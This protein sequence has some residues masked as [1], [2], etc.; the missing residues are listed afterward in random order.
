[1]MGRVR[2]NRMTVHQASS[3]RRRNKE[4][5][6]HTP[7]MQVVDHALMNQPDDPALELTDLLPA[8]RSLRVAVVTETYPPEVNGVAVTVAR[9]VEGLLQRGH[10]IQL[11][12]PRQDSADSRMNAS[13]LQEMLMR[14][15]PIPRYPQLRLGLPAKAALVAAW[16]K[17][18]PDMVHIATQGPLGWSALKAARKLRLP[19]STDFRTN[20]HA[21][22]RHYGLGWLNRT[23]VAYLRKFHNQAALTMVPTL[24]LRE[25]LAALGFER[26]CVVGRGVDTR[27]FGP[28]WRSPLLRDRW[29]VAVDDPVVLYVG[30]IAPEKNLDLLARAYEAMCQRRKNLRLVVVGEGPERDELG[31]RCPGAIFPGVQSGAELA[32]SYASADIFLFPSRTETYGNVTAEALASGL[33]VVAFDYAAAH[34]LIRHGHNGLLA[35]PQDEDAFVRRACDWLDQWQPASPMRLAARRSMMDRDWAGVVDQV[36]AHWWALIGAA[37]P[38]RMY[39]HPRV[40]L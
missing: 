33:G 9:L 19:V 40:A 18:R 31:R 4:R 12:R 37:Q 24:A 3:C 26:L 36:Q 22:S 10:E 11:V 15:M 8:H 2:E 1:M 34:E 14:G 6:C 20:F 39:V 5:R 7:V 13:G 27:R 25:Q 28:D 29:G 23:I 32:Q 16:H 21:Y 38:Q 30:R 35:S 17:R